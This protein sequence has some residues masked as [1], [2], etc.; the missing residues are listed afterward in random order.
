MA[1]GDLSGKEEYNLD[2]NI[3]KDHRPSYILQSL[4]RTASLGRT[5]QSLMFIMIK[6]SHQKKINYIPS[7]LFKKAGKCEIH[8][9]KISIKN[10]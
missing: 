1:T 9:R 10:D 2:T 7:T 3:H 8:F 6:P 4:S 5:A